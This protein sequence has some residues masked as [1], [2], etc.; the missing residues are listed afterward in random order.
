[1]D[2]ERRNL[3]VQV[4]RRYGE[5]RLKILNSLFVDCRIR[6]TATGITS[7]TSYVI[8]FI[9]TKTYINVEDGLSIGGGFIMYGSITT[10]GLVVLYMILPESEGRTLEEIEQFFSDTKRKLT[11]RTILPIASIQRPARES[12]G[13]SGSVRS[14]SNASKGNGSSVDNPAF[15]S[16]V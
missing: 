12:I 7:A 5:S 3:S 8:I 9:V 11:D 1:M 10:V 13:D 14:R 6:G 15:V 4:S 16:G 2:A